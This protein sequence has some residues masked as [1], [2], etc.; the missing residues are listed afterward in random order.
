V[1]TAADLQRLLST[2]PFA[3]FRLNLSDGTSVDILSPEVAI[4][5][6]RFALVGLLDPEA[7]DQ[8]V[9]RWAVVYYMHVTRAE[10]LKTGEP[11]FGPGRPPTAPESPSPAS[12]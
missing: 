6:R 2:R 4:V 1:F 5:G 11:P 10:M 8:L 3:A 7:A 12:A 9:D